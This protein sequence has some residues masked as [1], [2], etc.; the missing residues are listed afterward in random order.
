LKPLLYHCF[1]RTCKGNFEVSFSVLESILRDGLLLSEENVKIDCP[2]PEGSS[3]KLNIKQHRLCLTY[4]DE[5]NNLKDHC[6]LFGRIGIGFRVETIRC[7]GGFPVFYL[8]SPVKLDENNANDRLGVSLLYR[9]SEFRGVLEQIKKQPSDIKKVLYQ[10]VIDAE[11]L[12]GAVRFLGN[13][14][15]FTDYSGPSYSEPFRYYQQRE[16]RII[17]GVDSD[18][19]YTE[20]DESAKDFI[21]SSYQGIHIRQY[22]EDVVL[23]SSHKERSRCQKD[24]FEVET[25][26]KNYAISPKARIL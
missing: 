21:I 5:L 4:I 2:D 26:L 15:Y 18:E 14:F 8:P 7:I 9:L 24:L 23:L 6:R 25:L 13:I 19:A 22:I 11:E 20:N 10:N 16:W 3:S 1:S 12:E 17:A